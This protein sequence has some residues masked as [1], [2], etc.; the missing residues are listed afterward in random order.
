MTDA[1]TT[2]GTGVRP[3]APRHLKVCLPTGILMGTGTLVKA[4]E[5]VRVACF[6]AVPGSFVVFEPG[7][8]LGTRFALARAG[9]AA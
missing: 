1:T 9:E 8:P 6:S 5:D 2:A 3:A 4:G 7:G